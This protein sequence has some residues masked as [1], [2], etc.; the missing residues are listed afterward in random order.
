V[1]PDELAGMLTELGVD[2]VR[3]GDDAFL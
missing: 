1:T 3:E 2:A